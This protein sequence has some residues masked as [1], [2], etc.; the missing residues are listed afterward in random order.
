MTA[1]SEKRKELRLDWRETPESLGRKVLGDGGMITTYDDK[2]LMAGWY[3]NGPGEPSWYGAVYEQLDDGPL[4]PETDLGLAEI[5]P[6][7]FRDE[8]HAIEWALHSIK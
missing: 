7:F 8:G 2:I 5:S 4:D 6:G 3:Y 1:L